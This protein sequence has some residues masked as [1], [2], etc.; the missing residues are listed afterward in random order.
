MTVHCIILLGGSFDPV[1]NGHIAVAAFF[2][3]LFQAEGLRIIPTGNPWQ[4]KRLH[5]SAEQRLEMVRLA[6]SGRSLP[7][8][9]DSQEIVRQGPTYTIDTL[10]SLRSELGDKTSLVLVIGADQL[11]QFDTWREWQHLFDYAHI[12]VAARPGFS[13]FDSKL[14]QAIINE[15][16]RRSGTPDQ[17]RNS[18]NGLT[19]LAHELAFDISATEIRVAVQRGQKPDSL[20]PAEVLDYIEKNNIYKD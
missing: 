12:C 8:T 20:V 17:I 15:F 2:C 10:R 16:S 19:Y 4:K 5:A 18:P 14:P 11:Q 6:F 9:I 7:V 1:H 13:F 3:E